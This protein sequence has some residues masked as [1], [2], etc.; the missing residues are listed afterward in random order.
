VQ[1]RVVS[2]EVVARAEQVAAGVEETSAP[3][4]V[5][6]RSAVGLEA[7]EMVAVAMA[8]ARVGVAR[9][10]ERWAVGAAGQL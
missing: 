1:C 3:A 6:A 7:V 4:N 10:E 8:M 5:V 2:L 9:V